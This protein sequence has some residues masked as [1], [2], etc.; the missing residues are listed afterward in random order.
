MATT[1]VL[2]RHGKA[3]T[4]VEG[5]IDFDR[6]LTEAGRRSLA[7]T[8]NYELSFLAVDGEPVQVWASPSL[9]TVQTAD[10]LVDALDSIGIKVKG[11]VHEI[12]ALW[13]Q[14]Y[15]AFL[16]LVRACEEDVVIAVGHNPF[17]E[18]LTEK[19]TGAVLPVATGGLVAIRL[20]GRDD[21]DEVQ[22][23]ETVNETK[24]RI[25]W[26]AQG[27]VS[28]H[29]RTLVQMEK[30]IRKQAEVVHARLEA[31]F[32]DPDDIETMHKFRVSIRTLRSLVAFIKPWQDARQ[33]SG[34]QS[35][36][37][38]IVGV[39][40]RLR[41]LD[42]LSEQAEEAS[43]TSEGL[44]GFCKEQA[45]IERN[46]VSEALSSKQMQKRLN[47][48][49]NQAKSIEWKR[50]YCED[51]L[52]ARMVRARFD[53]LAENLKADLESLDIT[54]VEPTHDVRKSAKR[55]RYAAENF[56]DLIGDDAPGIAK[57]MQ[58]H[59][60]DLGAICDARVNIDIINGMEKRDDLPEPIAWDLALLRAENE[61][62]LYTTLRN[63]VQHSDEQV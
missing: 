47:R 31:F 49:S 33:N 6:E 28:Q 14:D 35:E 12:E 4:L 55:V 5:Q 20:N 54:E 57:G 37:K 58:A 43:F 8:L 46:K 17:V 19:L 39:T 41:E 40:S 25:L 21:Y 23:F 10:L 44:L 60:D 9:R 56:K 59:Q 62:F 13:E 34:M 2:M 63:Q 22:S 3:K 29:W 27:P 32:E 11:P 15:D 45:G 1:L 52:P 18:S 38:E 50:R 16:E 53:Q 61:T 24:D 42:V 26:F 48:V 36:L 51:G 7:A 30:T